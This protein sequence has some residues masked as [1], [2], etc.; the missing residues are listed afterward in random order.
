MQYHSPEE[1]AANQALIAAIL[2]RLNGSM[3]I[4][5]DRSTIFKARVRHNKLPTK[6]NP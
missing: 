6:S 5:C 1:L 2:I 3:L 4:Y